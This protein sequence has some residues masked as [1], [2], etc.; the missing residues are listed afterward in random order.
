MSQFGMQNE[1]IFEYISKQNAV[2]SRPIA[3]K[4]FCK[5]I[6]LYIYIDFYKYMYVLLVVGDN[7]LAGWL[8][9]ICHFAAL[10]CRPTESLRKFVAS[11]LFSFNYEQSVVARAL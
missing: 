4:F 10:R 7:L 1:N 5:C 2:I 11:G 8:F 3:I 9:A 6:L